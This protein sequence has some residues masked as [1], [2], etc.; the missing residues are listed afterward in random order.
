M[1]KKKNGSGGDYEVGH[2]KPPKHSR[3]KKGQS[4]NPKGRPK[5][6][7]DEALSKE[8]YRKAF[9]EVMNSDVPVRKNGRETTMPAVMAL[10]HQTLQKALSGDFRS[11]KLLFDK[12]EGNIKIEEVIREAEE[13]RLPDVVRIEFVES[14]GMGGKKVYEKSPGNPDRKEI[15]PDKHN[16]D[17]EE[18][19]LN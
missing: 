14:D 10:L 13:N 17:E 12:L 16:Q 1:T 8:E 11:K 15:L 5:K 3:Y 19:W 4:G 2:G 7:K 9:F 18:D 6:K